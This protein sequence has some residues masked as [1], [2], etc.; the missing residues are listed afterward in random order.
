MRAGR[1]RGS[2]A[3]ERR[4]VA[5]RRGA[6][7]GCESFGHG[8]LCRDSGEPGVGR[9]ASKRS[10]QTGMGRGKGRSGGGDLIPA[11]DSGGD[12]AG[13]RGRAEREAAKCLGCRVAAEMGG[14]KPGDEM[15]RSWDRPRAA[16]GPSFGYRPRH[17]GCVWR[18]NGSQAGWGSADGS[19]RR[20]SLGRA[21][22]SGNRGRFRD[23]WGGSKAEWN[24]RHRGRPIRMP[25]AKPSTR[26]A[27]TRCSRRASRTRP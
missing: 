19:K 27:A 12:A 11:Y 23:G 14:G 22:I 15:G 24:R 3:Q 13:G 7:K 26:P 16:A 17:P 9:I 6:G 21:A 25:G 5:R 4:G 1:G 2:V 8:L 20:Q 18:R 10:S